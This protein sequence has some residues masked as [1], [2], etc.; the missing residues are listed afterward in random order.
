[1]S[2]TRKGREREGPNPNVY[3]PVRQGPRRHLRH[4]VARRRAMPRRHHDHEEK[5]EVAELLDA[6]GRRHHRGRLSDR[7]GRRLRGRARDRQAHQECG[8]CRACARG[9]QGHRPRAEAIKPAP[10][11]P[12][13][14]L[15][16]DLAG[17][18]EVQAAEGAARGARDGDRAG[19]PGAQLHRRRRVVVGGRHPHRARLPLPLRRGRDQGRRDDD[20]PARHR[21]LHDAGGVLQPVQDRARAGAELR[22]GGLLGALPRRSRHGGGQFAR[23]HSRRRAPDRVHHQ[24]HRRARRQRGARRDRDGDAGAQRRAAVLDQASTRPC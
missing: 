8:R 23:R 1:M 15:R 22:Q 21:R 2:A 9:V 19:H 13:P 17:A 12:H 4:H 10:R 3:H 7:L 11:R 24:R 20:Q 14:Y 6:D 5:L 18:H 16:L